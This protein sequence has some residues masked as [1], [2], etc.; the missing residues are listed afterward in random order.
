MKNFV[1]FKKLIVTSGGDAAAVLRELL[2]EHVNPEETR[3]LEVLRE[4][5]A[6]PHEVLLYHTGYGWMLQFDKPNPG[7]FFSSP[8]DNVRSNINQNLSCLRRGK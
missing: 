2:I 4:R 6:T 1:G 3:T 7:G 5:P 8:T